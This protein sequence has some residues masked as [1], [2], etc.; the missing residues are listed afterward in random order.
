MAAG[1][2]VIRR[3]S[4]VSRILHHVADS[5]TAGLA[6]GCAKKVC[7]SGHREVREPFACHT[8][9]RN[10]GV[11]SVSLVDRVLEVGAHLRSGDLGSSIRQGLYEFLQVQLGSEHL[12]ASIQYLK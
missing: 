7:G 2:P 6:E 3:T 11:R 12:A 9:E 10:Q 8:G 4:S 5:D 1:Q